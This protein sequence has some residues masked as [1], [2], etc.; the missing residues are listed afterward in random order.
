MSHGPVQGELGLLGRIPGEDSNG[1][2]F[3]LK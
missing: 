3:N 1:I 2:H